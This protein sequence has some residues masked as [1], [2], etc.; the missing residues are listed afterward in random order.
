MTRTITLTQDV[1]IGGSIT[2][3]GTTVS[4][5]DGLAAELVTRKCA[6]YV[7]DPM[8]G[9]RTSEAQ[10]KL[11]ATGNVTGLVGP[12]GQIKLG[13]KSTKRRAILIGDSITA[14]NNLTNSVNISSVDG[15]ATVTHSV[16]Q[17]LLGQ[18]FRI[19]KS[20]VPEQNG[21]WTVASITDANTYTYNHVSGSGSMVGA[22]LMNPLRKVADGPFTWFNALSGA[23]FDVVRNYGQSSARAATVRA[24]LATQWVDDDAD[25]AFV[26]L[27]IND[28]N[29]D[30][31]IAS[32]ITDLEWIYQYVL[33]KGLVLNICTTLP[34]YTSHASFSAARMKV[35]HQLVEWQKQWAMDHT[36]VVLLDTHAAVVDPTSTT[37]SAKQ[38]YLRD[39]LHPGEMGGCY[40][41]AKMKDDK[42]KGLTVVP[43]GRWPTGALDGYDNNTAG[44][45]MLPNPM[46]LGTSGTLAGTGGG[47][48]GT[49]ATGVTATHNVASGS[50]F[51]CSIV[52]RADGGNDQRGVF[53]ATADN[54][55]AQFSYA[56]VHAAL[57]AGATYRIGA[58]IKLSDVSNLDY[59]FFEVSMQG[60]G[61]LYSNVRALSQGASATAPYDEFLE[62]SQDLWVESAEF[63]MPAGVTSAIVTCKLQ[64][65]GVGGAT[66]DLGRPKFELVRY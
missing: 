48:V 24:F 57:V 15:V 26:M 40:I 3:S 37:G 50:S 23:P 8:G 62:G 30:V 18:P 53:V 58:N 31:A 10:F 5:E 34:M 52:A 43:P 22:E 27:G 61:S 25:E 4:V 39:H 66:I 32:I 51:T 29:N 38:Y 35:V 9:E 49:V 28:V 16:H 14:Q 13:S 7:S 19:G 63:V 21:F 60:A 1:R 59:V 20:N 54:Q 45:N 47:A 33:G 42:Y 36:G 65:A 6:T 41:G 46:M 2:A 11:D 64:A 44:W 12:D 55:S 17:M 56:S